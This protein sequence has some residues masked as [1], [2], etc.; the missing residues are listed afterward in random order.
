M[1]KVLCANAD[2]GGC[3]YYRLIFP[4]ETC[5][6]D[7]G[8]EV[9]FNQH[10]PIH[11]TV[12]LRPRVV[13]VADLDINVLVL[14][15]PLQRVVAQSIPFWQKKG[16]AVVVDV[17]DDFSCLHPQHKARILY[18]PKRNPE[19]NWDWM[20]YAAKHADLVTCSTPALAQRYGA[21]G[22]A[23]VLEN[24]VPEAYLKVPKQSSGNTVG[25]A[26]FTTMHIDDLRVT[27][28]GVAEAVKTGDCRF[29]CVGNGEEVGEQLGL[30]LPIAVTGGVA[31][32]EYPNALAHLDVGLVPLLDTKFNEG[33]SYLKGLEYAALG[34]PFIA[35]SVAAYRD[36]W[37]RGLG[38]LAPDRARDWKRQILALVRDP[39]R[40]EYEGEILKD[41]VNQDHTYEGQWHRW[42]EA[43][44]MARE[45]RILGNLEAV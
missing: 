14:Q 26:G 24:C 36:L 33:K 27:R 41:L 31:F 43:W 22:N 21:H 37:G 15:R 8:I 20:R 35:S 10:L 7:E 11:R 25:W 34:I 18:D 40:I 19:T 13:A 9:E 45:R 3:G 6:Q 44:D 17:D 5:A 12:E 4:G 39:Q 16:I 1:L 23:I 28:G 38:Y 29:L 32:D 30:D 2:L 42:A